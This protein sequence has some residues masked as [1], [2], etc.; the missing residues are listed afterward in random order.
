MSGG[1]PRKRNP[2]QSSLTEVPKQD[3]N[4]ARLDYA[5]NILPAEKIVTTPLSVLAKTAIGKQMM[6][7]ALAAGHIAYNG[8]Y[9]ELSKFTKDMIG[10]G[11]GAQAFSYGVPYTA[12]AMGTA[13][14]YGK[15]IAPQF[16]MGY[17]GKSFDELHNLA[18]E[19]SLEQKYWGMRR[20]GHGHGIAGKDARDFASTLSSEGFGEVVLPERQG[21]LHTVEIDDP[22]MK[23][24]LHWEKDLPDK[25]VAALRANK[26]P[27]ERNQP[28]GRVHDELARYINPKEIADTVFRAGATGTRYDANT[29]GLGNWLPSKNSVLYDPEYAKIIGVT[30]IKRQN[31]FPY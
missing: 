13:E 27:A 17:G 7:K 20:L 31:D 23:D 5:L 1:E 3:L 21:Y 14:T 19:G 2:G 18:K 22:I 25:Y 10:K 26:M 30:P 11:E 28:W 29:A 16:R 9:A 6:A 24:M 12:D 15:Y 4:E 8:G